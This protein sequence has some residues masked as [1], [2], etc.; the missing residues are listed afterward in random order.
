MGART[1]TGPSLQFQE[2]KAEPEAP[3]KAVAVEGS[4]CSLHIT[5]QGRVTGVAT[6]SSR[7]VKNPNPSPVA[8][9]LA[10]PQ[11]PVAA[12]EILLQPPD[13]TQGYQ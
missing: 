10:P 1:G 2:D 13:H 4:E 8:A 12:A 7:L 11:R 6:A 9:V 5:A 3:A